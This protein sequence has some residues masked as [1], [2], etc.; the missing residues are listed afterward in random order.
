MRGDPAPQEYR[1]DGATKD[2]QVETETMGID[3]LD[4]QREPLGPCGFV[5]PADLCETGQS[6]P[7]SM[8]T[9]LRRRVVG[10]V[11]K[12]QRPWPDERHIAADDVPKSGEFVKTGP[13]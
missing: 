12:E 10:H 2:E 5:S 4:V 8:P 9:G 13:S 6:G 1:E 11:V 7:D 3:V